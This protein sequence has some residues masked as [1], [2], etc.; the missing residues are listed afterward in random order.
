MKKVFVFVSIFFCCFLYNVKEGFAASPMKPSFEVK[1]LLK[2]EQVLG[3]NKEMKQEVLEHFQAGTKY[4]RIQVQFLDTANKSLSEEGWFARIRKKEFSKDFELTY[5]KRYPIPNGVIQDALEVAKKEGFDS[6]TDSYEAEIDWGFEKKTLSISNKKS[7]S[8]KGYGILDL[9][10]EQATQ[11]M[12][13]EKLPGKMNKWLY[14]NW[15]E[16]MLKSSRIYGPVLMKRYT[17]EFENIKANIEIWPLSNTGKLEDDFVIEVSFKTNEESIAT[18][19]RELLMASLEKKGW[20]LPKD[21][22]KT[23]LIFQ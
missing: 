9:P 8:A 17:G 3:D 15:G 18:K 11:N 5:K 12:L 10:N 19:Q 14:T 1:L 13:I 20:L 22:L 23:E 21:S 6:N 4:E 2:P 16:E 7:Y